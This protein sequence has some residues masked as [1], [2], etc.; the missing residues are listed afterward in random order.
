[1][2]LVLLLLCS[3][4]QVT[5]Q[6]ETVTAL[7][8]PGLGAIQIH[9][10]TTEQV[11]LNQAQLDQISAGLFCLDAQGFG[12]FKAIIEQLCSFHPTE[13]NYATVVQP[14]MDRLSSIQTKIRK[15][16]K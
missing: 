9:T 14:V 2:A 1:M 4:A 11:N 16:K 5:I 12:D 7:R 8:G 13:C 10:L 6:D 15:H 3:C